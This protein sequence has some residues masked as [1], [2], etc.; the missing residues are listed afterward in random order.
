MEYMSW[1]DDKNNKCTMPIK[2]RPEW[3]GALTQQPVDTP[4][5]TT[6]LDSCR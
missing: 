6:H 3:A 1:S 5:G 2:V 4:E